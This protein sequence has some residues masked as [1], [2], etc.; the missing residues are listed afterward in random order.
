MCVWQ[1]VFFAP[2][3]ST[4]G[5]ATL[6]APA[7][8]QKKTVCLLHPALPVSEPPLSPLLKWTPRRFSKL[9]SSPLHSPLLL[10]S[11]PAHKPPPFA[12][13]YSSWHVTGLP[14]FIYN[15]FVCEQAACIQRINLTLITSNR[16]FSFMVFTFSPCA[17]DSPLDKREMPF[18]V[19]LQFVWECHKSGYVGVV[20]FLI[21]CC[22]L[23]KVSVKLSL[24][25][26]KERSN[27][28]FTY[29][30]FIHCWDYL[31]I[32]AGCNIFR[33]CVTPTVVSAVSFSTFRTEVE[34][35]CRTWEPA[36]SV[37]VLAD[38]TVWG[39]ALLSRNNRGGGGTDQQ[40]LFCFGFF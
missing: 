27:R 7:M 3:F 28:Y 12:S 32:R 11:P 33:Y 15:L 18:D 21:C 26:L 19:V 30:T 6:Q 16:G 13:K 10:P 25:I 23:F 22:F 2:W 31:E 8:A 40:K 35:R 29:F 24:P 5:S 39:E 14:G 1:W 17:P 34:E 20:S 9:S 37:Q 38:A 4:G 36:S